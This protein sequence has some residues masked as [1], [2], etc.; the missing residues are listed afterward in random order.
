MSSVWYCS[1]AIH[2]WLVKGSDK[3]KKLYSAP[4]DNCKIDFNNDF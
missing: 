4:E 2:I 3:F 1:F